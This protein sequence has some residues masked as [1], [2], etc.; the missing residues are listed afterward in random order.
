QLGFSLKRTMGVAQRL[1]EGIDLGSEGTVGLI[2]YMR[3]DSTRVSPEAITAVRGWIKAKL[4]DKYL[5]QAP[6]AFKSKK[7]AQDAHEAIRP[8]DPELLPDQIKK[9]LS[10]EQYKLYKLI[11]QRFV[12]SQMMPAVFDQTT[13]DIVAKADHSYDFRGTGSVLKFDGFLKV[14]EESKEKKDEDDEALSN[15]LPALNPGDRLTLKELKPEQHFTEPPPRY[16][17]ASLVK[18]LEERGIGRPSTYASIIN[19]IQDREYVQKMGGRSGTLVPTEIGTVVT[20]LLVKNFPYIFDST[21]TAKLETE[22]DDI[23][24]GREKWTDLLSGFYSHFADELKEADKKMEDIQA[25][26]HAT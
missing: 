5:P 23:E 16:N 2:T 6:N 3:T 12:A 22:L 24:D 20:N 15:K 26:E 11:W 18:E 10:D 9:Y 17:E 19:T 25:M 4:G 7:D 13:V 1:Y 14:Y 21:Y 8:S